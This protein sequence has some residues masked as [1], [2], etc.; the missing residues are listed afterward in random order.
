[1]IRNARPDKT[2][3]V[4]VAPGNLFLDERVTHEPT[5]TLLRGQR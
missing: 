1:M 4:A 3:A 2:V 5:L